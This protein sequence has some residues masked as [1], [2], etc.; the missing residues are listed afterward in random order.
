MPVKYTTPADLMLA[1]NQ[2][3][4]RWEAV[5]GEEERDRASEERFAYVIR[6]ASEQ[7]GKGVVVLVDEYDKPLL[8]TI[9]NEPLL[10]SLTVLP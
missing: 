1:L 7:T 3:L 2:H 5:Y 10:L 6:R 9:Q 8:H 4:E